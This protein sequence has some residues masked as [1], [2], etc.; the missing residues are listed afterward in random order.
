MTIS[1]LTFK[2]LWLQDIHFGVPSIPVGAV[3]QSFKMVYEAAKRRGIRAV[4]IGGD[5]TDRPLELTNDYGSEFVQ[6]G[7]WLIK[8]A[9]ENGITIIVLEGTP[10]HDWKQARILEQL[11]TSLNSDVKLIYVSSLSIVYLEDFGQVL[12]VPDQW[13]AST[14]TTLM[15]V[16]TL[17]R[18]HK[19]EQVDWAFMH[20]SFEYQV[21]EFLR[22]R[23]D[24]HDPKEYNKIV[25]KGIFIG[26]E[27]TRSN[28]LKIQCAGSLERTK[29]GQ[30][31]EKGGLL[32]EEMINGKIHIEF[33]RNSKA[34]IFKD[35]FVDDLTPEQIFNQIDKEGIDLEK[36]AN[37]RL[38]ATKNVDI[39]SEFIKKYKLVYPEI[40]W[41]VKNLSSKEETETLTDVEMIEFSKVNLDTNTIKELLISRLS[42][43]YPERLISLKAV[44][45]S[46][47]DRLEIT[48]TE[49][50]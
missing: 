16:K 45:D 46:T 38:T 36:F 10:S 23:L 39:V 9:E 4:V 33:I 18:E 20:G 3:T 11:K 49:N 7:L 37:I 24:L 25:K 32:I 19:L 41:S 8:D 48:G 28:Y 22:K 2:W 42:D 50:E 29:H 30:E 14:S 15:E 27:H 35:I 34:Q 12:F 43:K 40:K 5:I 26:H 6:F 17:L 47:I 13:R 21:A 44:L 31:E 1:T